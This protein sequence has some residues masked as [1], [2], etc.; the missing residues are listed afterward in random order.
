ML[1]SRFFKFCVDFCILDVAAT[2]HYHV[3]SE[4]VR[5]NYF[6]LLVYKLVFLIVKFI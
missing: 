1:I 3:L 5:D 4:D 2:N 6:L